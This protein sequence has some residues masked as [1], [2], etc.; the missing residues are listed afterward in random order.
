MQRLEAYFPKNVAEI[1]LDG[2]TQWDKDV[3]LHVSG[4]EIPE[5]FEIHIGYEGIFEVVRIPLRKIDGVATV[6]I[7]NELLQQTRD[8]KAWVYVIDSEGCRTTKTINIPLAKREKPADYE[9]SIEP[10]Q[11]DAVEQLVENTNKLLKQLE[12]EGIIP[13]IKISSVTLYADQWVGEASPYSQSV[14]ISGATINSKINLNPTVE[15]LNIFYN[16]D[17]SFVVENDD[18]N[19]TVY[20]IGQKPTNDYTMQATVMGVHI[21]G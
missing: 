13:S 9:T 14:E 5:S 4:D 21:D 15:Q 17:I 6:K 18:G 11:K 10:S 1:V 19:I 16:K 8:V 12:E 7:P 2:L 3:L 20:C